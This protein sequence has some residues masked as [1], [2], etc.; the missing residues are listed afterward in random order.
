MSANAW[1]GQLT[2]IF[3]PTSGFFIATLV[4]GKI[5]FGKWIRFHNPLMRT[6]TLLTSIALN[7]MQILVITF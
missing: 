6:F 7:L 5:E 1:S 4:I 3:F 2:D